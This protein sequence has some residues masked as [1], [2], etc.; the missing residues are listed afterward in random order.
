MVAVGRGQAELPSHTA[1]A[2][3]PMFCAHGVGD[4]GCR[5]QHRHKNFTACWSEHSITC[6]RHLRELF[7]CSSGFNLSLAV[8]KLVLLLTVHLSCPVSCSPAEGSKR[9]PTMYEG[10]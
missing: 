10:C 9:R 1:P 6:K 2:L 4:C 8:G 7:I 5:V 3:C